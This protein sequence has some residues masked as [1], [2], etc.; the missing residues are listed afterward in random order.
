MMLD[1]E[2]KRIAMD[3]PPPRQITYVELTLHQINPLQIDTRQITRQIMHDLNLLLQQSCGHGRTVNEE[4]L[5]YI[6]QRD[7]RLFV[8]LDEG[9]VVGV[10]LLVSVITLVDEHDLVRDLLVHVDYRSQEREITDTL[11]SMVERVSNRRRV[12]G[13]YYL[14]D[15]TQTTARLV[16]DQHGYKPLEAGVFGRPH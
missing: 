7:M 13:L 2:G 8:A 14:L 11:M 5:N 10:A 1:N 15:T 3:T 9:R 16:C 4:R 12:E 6:F